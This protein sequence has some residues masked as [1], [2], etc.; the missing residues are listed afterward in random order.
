MDKARVWIP[1]YIGVWMV[2][3]LYGGSLQAQLTANANFNPARIETGDTFSLRVLVTGTNSEPQP[4]DFKPWAAV[5]QGNNVLSHT[6]WRRSGTQWVQQFTLICFDSVQM[7]L[8]PLLIKSHLGETFPTNALQLDVFP[9]KTGSEIG[10]MDSIREIIRE[11]A[12]WTDF[13]PWYVGACVLLVVA[14]RYLRKPKRPKPQIIKQPDTPVVPAIPIHLIA[15]QRLAELE[16]QK[17]WTKGPI[18]AYYV[19]LSMIVREYLE[20]RF[21]IPALE[22]TTSETKQM[23]AHVGVPT[24]L[25]QSIEKLLAQTDLVKYASHM[26]APDAHLK[27]LHQ[28]QSIIEKTHA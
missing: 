1:I 12:N 14:M 22:S 23:L 25:L 27:A 24:E 16:K 8:P 28:A 20:K 3:L 9:T 15:L 11:P 19:E 5:F 21:Q 13:W 17:A 18:K 26:P 6:G 2:T 4:V 10:D 7:E